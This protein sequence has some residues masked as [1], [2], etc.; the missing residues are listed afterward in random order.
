MAMHGGFQF[1]LNLDL[2][3]ISF[4]DVVVFGLGK[5]LLFKSVLGRCVMLTSFRIPKAFAFCT[6]FFSSI[7]PSISRWILYML[8]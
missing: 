3:G 2:W 8:T 1:L 5:N 7:H 4:H 6:R